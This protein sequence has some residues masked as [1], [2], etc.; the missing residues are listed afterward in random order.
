MSFEWHWVVIAAGVVI[1]GLALVAAVVYLRRLQLPRSTTPGRATLILPLTGLAPG[2]EDLLDALAA[3]TLRPRRLLIAVE[4]RA[5]PAYSRAITA[6]NRCPFPI[7]V[8]IAGPATRCGQKCWNQIA[9]A[10]RIDAE[11]EV[12]VL[13]DA[14]IRPQAWWL[15]ALVAPIMDGAADIVTG[16]RWPI[17]ARHT[18]GVHLIIAIDRAIGLLPRLQWA[19]ATWGGTLAL[20]QGAF[21][22]LE[23]RT[24]LARTLSDDSTIGEQA[25]ARGL[26]VLTRRALL[27][28][29]PL[30]FDVIQAWRFGRRQYQI[31]NVHRPLV[32]AIAFLI[33][34]ARVAAWGVVIAH[35]GTSLVAQLGAVLLI[36]LAITKLA[37]RQGIAARLGYRDSMG[38][39]AAQLGLAVLEPVVDLF[40]W[41][42]VLAAAHTR[43]VYW[44]HLSY[45]VRGPHDVT[46]TERAPWHS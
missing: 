5:D 2:L 13:L 24:T 39:R 16:Y 1:S 10:E 45:E 17:A 35:L 11:D 7:E 31:M 9:A 28:K 30:S 41:S 32:W 43:R 23:F 27:V 29:T 4:A 46:V 19:R 26:R 22:E 40:H 44:G 12:I 3:Q 36:G 14:D 38:A 21:R 8:I 25:G 42:I 6:K 37:V 33:L 18:L 34:T 20:S 15:S